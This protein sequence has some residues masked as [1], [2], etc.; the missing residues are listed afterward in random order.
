MV[1]CW[2]KLVYSFCRANLWFWAK[3]LLRLR[4]DARN[5]VPRTG[6]VLVV[7]NHVSHLDPPLVGLAVPRTAFH[8][9]KK[10]LFVLPPLMWFMRTIGTIMVDRGQGSQ[11]LLDAVDY[12]RKDACVII[13]P[14][15]TRSPDGVLSRG[16]SGAVVIAARTNCV[17]VPTAIIGSEKA[18]TKGSKMIK[19]VPVSVRFGP[20][21]TLDYTG[22]PDDIPRDY[23][24]RETYLMMQRIEALLP[25]YMRPSIACK[26]KWYGE[27]A[28]SRAP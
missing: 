19:P 26:Q 23:L 27:L 2:G 17:I 1:S 9:A 14:E 21:Y 5:H 13:F 3:L 6:P 25:D 16:H 4:F 28:D 10:E 24:R 11:A 15:G 7:S 12:L 8:M 22:D 18:M 20:A